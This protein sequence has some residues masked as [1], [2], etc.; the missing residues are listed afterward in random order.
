MTSESTREIER[1]LLLSIEEDDWSKRSLTDASGKVIGFFLHPE[2]RDLAVSALEAQSNVLT[3][4]D[5]FVEALSYIAN[6]DTD[7]E[8]ARAVAAKCADNAKRYADLFCKIT[9]VE[10][11]TTIVPS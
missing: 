10:F 8:A 6:P 4:M 11:I 2:D 1:A 7:P 3:M 5:T 9:P